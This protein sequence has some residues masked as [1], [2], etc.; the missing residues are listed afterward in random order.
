[1]ATIERL[2][3]FPAVFQAPPPAAALLGGNY[4]MPCLAVM[5]AADSLLDAIRETAVT[6]LIMRTL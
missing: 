1:M 5:S 2:Q 4:G 6:P 3:L